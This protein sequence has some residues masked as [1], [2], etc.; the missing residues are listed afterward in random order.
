MFSAARVKGAPPRTVVWG[1]GAYIFATSLKE[2][3]IVTK[4]KAKESTSDSQKF[5]L[6]ESNDRRRG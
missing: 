2:E 3:N 6:H 4:P 5:V 1:I